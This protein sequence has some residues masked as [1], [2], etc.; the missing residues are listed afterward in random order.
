MGNLTTQRTIKEIY[1]LD[2]NVL[3]SEYGEVKFDYVKIDGITFTNYGQYSFIWEKSYVESPNRSNDGSMPTLNSAATFVVPHF[4]INFSIISIDD[5]RLLM[6]TH[7]E[8]N[9]H[10][11]EFYD[12]VYNERITR[13]LYFATEEM[14]KFHVL[15]RRR[16]VEGEQAFED[17]CAIAGVED[18]TLEMIGTNN[19]IDYLNV[20]YHYNPP[21]STGLSD[22]TIGEDSIYSGDEFIIGSAA[23]SWYSETFSGSYRFDKWVS[24]KKN[25][26]GIYET[27]SNGNYIIEYE[28]A[29]D[30]AVTVYSDLTLYAV[31]Q[32]S[33]TFKL[34][35][36]YGLA[37]PTIENGQ[38]VYS[39]T[40]TEGS[41]IGSLPV[42]NPSLQVTYNDTVYPSVYTN[43]TWRKTN[44]VNGTAVLDTDNYWTNHD[45]II[46]FV[47][48][49]SKYNVSYVT[50]FAGITL[51]DVSV[52]YGDEVQLPTLY[53]SG[54][55][56][57]GWYTDDS[58]KTK[59][60]GTMPP[61]SIKLYAKWVE[62]ND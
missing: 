21:E 9:E 34:T 32:S 33:S 25:S 30:S 17:F 35:Y 36:S 3:Y 53:Y 29:A 49:T 16:F 60:S 57:E 27:D 26:N 48:E 2:V 6:R 62:N 44:S 12:A 41:P 22:M 52:A 7:L 47:Y 18:Y 39:K 15:N 56:F 42:V 1:G 59:F 10:V 45:S 55:S 23:S 46:Y 20:I 50:Y 13:K 43:G 61:Y 19:S 54:Y 40:V 37:T 31:W 58:F 51:G 8:K 38:Y 24:Y 4:T 5:W 11:V 28:Y 14:P